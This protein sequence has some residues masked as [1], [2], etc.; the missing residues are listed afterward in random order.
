MIYKELIDRCKIEILKDSIQELD[1][2]D[3]EYFSDKF[4]DY[5][6]NSSLKNINPDEDGSPEKFFNEDNNI[7]TSSL[8]F[9]SLVHEALLQPN[10]FELIQCIYKPSNKLGTLLDKIYDL[11][12]KH[13]KIKDAI[14]KASNE[15]DYY[16]NKISDKRIKNI[17]NSGLKYYIYLYK[18]NYSENVRV[19]D[20]NLFNKV[21][22]C[23]DSCYNTFSKKIKNNLYSEFSEYRNERAFICDIKITFP[24]NNSE[25]I[26]FK[27]KIDNFII[28]NFNDN[29]ILNDLK[30]TGKN[31]NLFFNKI[32]NEEMPLGSFYTYHYY[33]QLAVYKYILETKYNK[34]I[35]SNLMIV[36]SSYPFNYDIASIDTD[37]LNYGLYEFKKLL[38]FVAF[39]KKNNY[40]NEFNF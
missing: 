34:Q 18:S 17:I 2:S 7:Y 5:V 23:I 39:Y 22:D 29:I 1:I 9:G 3:E 21:K 31:I 20:I 33:R 32:I 19:L 4:K 16:K 36:E 26:K 30:T 10:S 27:S 25:I 6:S 40:N 13:Y 12:K 15:V 24:N 14:I 28:D 37:I 8:Q 38:C 35:K 11:R